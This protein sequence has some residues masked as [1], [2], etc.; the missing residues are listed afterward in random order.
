MGAHCMHS[1]L[2]L[3]ELTE[4]ADCVLPIDNQVRECHNN[5][6]LILCSFSLQSLIDISQKVFKACQSRVGGGAKR[7]S[8]V[9]AGAGG[10]AASREKPFDTM[11]N[12]VA[13]LLLNLTR[14]L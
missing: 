3:H 11:N 9:T 5:Y 8:T 13:N 10:L 4:K 14:L 12:I 2:A 7:E 6:Q 1:V